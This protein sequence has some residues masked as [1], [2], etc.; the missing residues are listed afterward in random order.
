MQTAMG[1]GV[2]LMPIEASTD[3][4]NANLWV[5]SRHIRQILIN[6]MSNAVKYTPSGG[7]VK[8]TAE[9]IGD[10][11]K[12]NVVDTGVGISDE[13]LK[14]LFERFERGEDKY[15]LSQQGTGLGLALT[16]HLA[17]I[18]GGTVGVDSKL[19]EGST[20]WVLVPLAGSGFITEEAQQEDK[21]EEEATRL[22]GLNLLVVDDNELTCEVL[23]TIISKAG[24]MAYVAHSVTE[25]KVLATQVDLD[26]ALIDLAMPRESGLSLIKYFRKDCSPP[27]SSMPLI[28]VS[29]CVFEKDKQEAFEHGASQF[30]A[31]PFKPHDLLAVIRKLTISS[32]L[33]TTG[34]FRAIQ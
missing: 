14:T 32:V 22:D 18:N 29:A 5:D 13:K 1:K 12:I 3:V 19:G 30:V 4:K 7:T 31:K 26:A 20:F 6:L 23:N 15:S 17:E 34:S 28:V 9:I 16:K 21:E 33:N 25:A 11:V 2:K 24:G 8:L 10:K 27:L